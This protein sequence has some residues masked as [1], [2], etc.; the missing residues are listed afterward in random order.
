MSKK[1]QQVSIATPEQLD[2]ARWVVEFHDIQP[3]VRLA[4]VIHK[5]SM[6]YAF[7]ANIQPFQSGDEPGV[8]A[9]FEPRNAQSSW[10]YD[11]HPDVARELYAV[12]MRAA[13]S[14]TLTALPSARNT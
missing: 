4:G 2:H 3:G 9:T 7:E 5:G 1:T 11:N 10:L 12:M 6:S 8:D 13:F 14:P